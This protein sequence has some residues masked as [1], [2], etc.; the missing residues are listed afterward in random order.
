[1]TDSSENAKA[2]QPG[3][4][5]QTNTRDYFIIPEGLDCAYTRREDHV[6]MWAM[7]LN[8]VSGYQFA[9][10]A[11]AFREGVTAVYGCMSGS[12]A[13]GIIHD[14]EVPLILDRIGLGYW[15]VDH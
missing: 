1:M 12:G 4:H 13:G 2:P 10:L 11:I 8:A 3:S 9:K 6:Q 15:N 7:L 14:A 5:Y